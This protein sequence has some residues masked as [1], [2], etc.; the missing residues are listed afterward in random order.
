MKHLAQYLVL[1][2]FSLNRWF[3]VFCFLFSIMTFIKGASK[4][5]MCNVPSHAQRTPESGRVYIVPIPKGN[6]PAAN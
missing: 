2:K 3:F 6:S 1:N 5:R 4:A